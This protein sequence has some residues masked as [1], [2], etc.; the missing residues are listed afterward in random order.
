MERKFPQ[1]EICTNRLRETRNS[2]GKISKPRE[3][4]FNQPKIIFILGDAIELVV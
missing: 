4:P 1:D 2:L 3:P